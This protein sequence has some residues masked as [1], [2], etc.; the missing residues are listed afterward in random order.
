MA[1]A[2][3]S[4]QLKSLLHPG[5]GGGGSSEAIKIDVTALSSSRK[6]NLEVQCYCHKGQVLSDTVR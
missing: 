6:P 2:A 3:A 4:V 1:R 5:G